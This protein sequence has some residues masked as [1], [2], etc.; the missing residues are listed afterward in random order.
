MIVRLPRAVPGEGES[1][2]LSLQCPDSLEPAD[3]D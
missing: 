1:D 3:E 2:Y